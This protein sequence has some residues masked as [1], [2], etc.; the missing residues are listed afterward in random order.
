M[1]Y[2]YFNVPGI[3]KLTQEILLLNGPKKRGA[4]RPAVVQEEINQAIW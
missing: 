4:D 3:M 1:I 2:Q